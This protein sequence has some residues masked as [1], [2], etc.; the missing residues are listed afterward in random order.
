MY[1]LY[2]FGSVSDAANPSLVASNTIPTILVVE[3]EV[4]VRLA[5]ADYLRDCGYKVFEAGNVAEAKSVLNADASVDLVFS[6]VQMPGGETGFDLAVWVRRHYP[7]IRVII[8]SGLP[9]AAEK[10]RDVCHEGPVVAKP[11]DH[12]FVLVRI[13]ALLR[14]G[15]S[16]A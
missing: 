15:G 4:L 11:Y 1:V 9:N 2:R 10:A 12:D 14:N 5:I 6:D 8:T 13:Q 7:A 3:D 16:K